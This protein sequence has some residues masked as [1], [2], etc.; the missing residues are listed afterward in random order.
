MVEVL[1][2]ALNVCRHTRPVHSLTKE[3]EGT[4]CARMSR[5]VVQILK[6]RWVKLLG[7][8]KLVYLTLS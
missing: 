3:G 5:P 7:Q 8:D 1:D 4:L 6:Y 2:V